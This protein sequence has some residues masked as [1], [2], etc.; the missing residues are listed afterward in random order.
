MAC[1]LENLLAAAAGF[2]VLLASDNLSSTIPPASSA[3]AC[4]GPLTPMSGAENAPH[5]LRAV[6]GT[7]RSVLPR[8]VRPQYRDAT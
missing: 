2:V 3:E 4:V 5:D 1:S 8:S 6:Y 7:P